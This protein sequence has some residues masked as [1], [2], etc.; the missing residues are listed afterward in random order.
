MKILFIQKEGGIFGA[1][2]YHLQIIPALRSKGVTI[3]FLRLYTD[4]QLGIDSDFVKRL[5]A[6]KIAVHQ[7]NIG[8]MPGVRDVRQVAGIIRKG[9]YDIIHSHL[10]HADLYSALVKTLYKV[11]S[12]FVSTKH[13]YDNAY[14]A[15]YGFNHRHVRSTPYYWLSRWAESVMDKSYTIS[16]GL[17]N[18]FVDAGLSTRSKMELIYYGFDLPAIQEVPNLS[19]Y[20]IATHQLCIAGRLVEFKG[21]AWAMQALAI[22]KTKYNNIRLVIIGTGK[23]Q[24]TLEETAKH[25]QVFEE[26]DWLGYRNDVALWMNHSD[27]VLIP[28]RSEGFGVVFL[29]AFNAG[30]PV[31]AFNVPAANELILHEENGLLAAPY[32]EQELAMCVDRLLESKELARKL[33]W[34]AA[35]DLHTKFSLSTMTEATL[36]FYKRVVRK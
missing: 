36:A 16:K 14:T 4:Y 1:E 30:T 11:P 8:R 6:M 15:K 21:H 28:S 17:L 22:L 19:N 5:Q 7:V 3:E 13:G 2:H 23:H 10:I 35:S 34:Q 32:N 33:A 9:S 27:V 25:L 26:I 20:R 18:F 12:I 29:E 24:K 31:V